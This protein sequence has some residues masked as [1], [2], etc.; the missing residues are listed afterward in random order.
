MPLLPNPSILDVDSSA[1]ILR[2]QGYRAVVMQFLLCGLAR[3]WTTDSR[4]PE[5]WWTLVVEVKL[6]G[7]NL[8][9]IVQ[10]LMLKL[11]TETFIVQTS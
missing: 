9:R 8:F 4:R 6:C 10:H 1:A 5:R 7:K 3:R 11:A 2:E